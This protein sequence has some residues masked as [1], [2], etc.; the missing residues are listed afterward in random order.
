M[1][2][3]AYQTFIANYVVKAQ[4]EKYR[5]IK[6]AEAAVEKKYQEK[7]QLLLQQSSPTPTIAPSTKESTIPLLDQ[8]SSTT[9]AAAADIQKSISTTRVNIGAAIANGEYLGESVQKRV[10]QVVPSSSSTTSVGITTPSHTKLFEIRSVKVLQMANA[11]QSRWGEAEIQKLKNTPS[12]TTTTS[13]QPPS[14]ST[15]STSTS[16]D[17]F[18]PVT[19]EE[20]LRLGAKLEPKISSISSLPTTHLGKESLYS[21]RTAKVMESANAGKSRWGDA[22]IMKLQ[23]LP[24]EPKAP[25]S[26]ALYTMRT[27]KV[28][29]SAD[30]GK[31][32]W[33]DAEIKKLSTAASAESIFKPPSSPTNF[34]S[35]NNHHVAN[36]GAL[37]ISSYLLTLLGLSG[38]WAS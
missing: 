32:R 2:L 34:L 19:L 37:L 27:T 28:I 17:T 1:K 15:K 8:G 11:G 10:D 18:R 29:Q 38:A 14:I 25:R 35:R 4:E 3:T 24:K 23:H 16:V 33:G 7:L 20:R 21:L 30:A 12:T 9:T 26:D 36:V 31:S 5:A 6:R 22:E 13:Q